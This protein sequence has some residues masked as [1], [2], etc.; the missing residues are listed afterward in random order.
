MKAL[1]KAEIIFYIAAFLS[2]FG[3]AAIVKMVHSE[4]PLPD[5]LGPCN[6]DT[7]HCML[8]TGPER[9]SSATIQF[10]DGIRLNRRIDT[11]LELPSALQNAQ[12]VTLVLEGRDMYLGVYE[13]PLRKLP[14]NTWTNKVVVPLCTD[15][16]MQW[17]LKVQLVDAMGRDQEWAYLFDI[18][19][20]NEAL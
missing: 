6:L 9:L 2:I 17:V 14:D 13:Y 19:N 5:A 8:Q 7:G 10:D 16:R 12:E 1:S 11:T 15:E 20:P 18:E 3:V 4:D